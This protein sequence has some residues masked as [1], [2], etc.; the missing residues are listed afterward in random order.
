MK[1]CHSSTRDSSAIFQPRI[2]SWS[3]ESFPE[4]AFLHFVYQQLRHVFMTIL[5]MTPKVSFPEKTANPIIYLYMIR[6]HFLIYEV[7][8]L[9]LFG[10]GHLCFAHDSQPVSKAVQSSPLALE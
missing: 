5:Q 7:S 3:S 6:V 10:G 2:L 1:D 9:I 4:S 8:H